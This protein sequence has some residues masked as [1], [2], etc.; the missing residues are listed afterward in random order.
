MTTHIPQISLLFKGFLVLLFIF[1]IS[2]CATVE[3]TSSGSNDI[4]LI[5]AAEKG[6][7]SKINKMLEKGV[8]V[9]VKHQSGNTALIMA[10]QNSYD[11]IVTTLL[12][13]GADVNI[14]NNEGV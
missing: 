9:N 2:G 7:I 8:N 1:S 5:I 13:H 11:E 12:A 4:D 10:S 3:K 6:D 14:V